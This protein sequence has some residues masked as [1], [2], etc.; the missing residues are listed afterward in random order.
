VRER[1]RVYL[2]GK[3][4]DYN[5]LLLIIVLILYIRSLDSFTYISATLHPFTYIYPSLT[6][7]HPLRVDRYILFLNIS[8]YLPLYKKVQAIWETIAWG[9]LGEN[10]AVYP[11]SPF[12][13]RVPFLSLSPPG[14]LPSSFSV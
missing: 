10:E 5:T 2:F 9:L 14:F 13:S 11:F 3:T 1:E 7:P 8:E 12:F 6:I 4:P